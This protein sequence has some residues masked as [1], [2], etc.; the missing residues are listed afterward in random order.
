MAESLTGTHIYPNP[1]PRGVS[2]FSDIK[3]A[4]PEH[5]IE[6]VFDVGASTGV[7][8]TSYLTNFPHSSVYC[9][10]PIAETYRQL[11]LN[12]SDDERIRCFQLALGAS[13]GEGNMLSQGTSTMNRLVDDA[14]IY[15]ADSVKST[16][17][18][19]IQTV[20]D[21]CQAHEIARIHYLKVDTE[22]GDLDVLRGAETL[23]VG[24]SV[25]LVEV[26]AG[27]NPSNKHHVPFESLK[28]HLEQRG[29]YLFGIYEQLY[30]WP[31]KEPH[32]RRSNLVF[33]SRDMISTH[34]KI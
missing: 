3:R 24:Q 17:L 20:D 31:S 10:E 12:T 30:E 26:E 8:A 6:V 5:R 13:R 4:L 16:E 1:L 15:S 28:S 18:V 29:Y 34:K 21:F 7:S 33:M 19:E 2:I 25:D 27:M 11:V 23:L 9:F 22:G 14:S 32:L